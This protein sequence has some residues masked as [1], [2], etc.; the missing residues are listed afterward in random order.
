MVGL[1]SLQGARSDQNKGTRLG[2]VVRPPQQANAMRYQV[3]GGQIFSG[4]TR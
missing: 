2:H 4:L 3:A 1:P